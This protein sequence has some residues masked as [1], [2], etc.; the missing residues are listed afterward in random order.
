MFQGPPGLKGSH[1]DPGLDGMQVNRSTFAAGTDRDSSVVVGGG[2]VKDVYSYIFFYDIR[3][4]SRG[5]S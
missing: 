5:F 2:G 1:G 4:L 3:Y